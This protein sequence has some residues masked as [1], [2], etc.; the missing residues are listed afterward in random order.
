VRGPHEQRGGKEQRGHGRRESDDEHC[1]DRGSFLDEQRLRMRG[2]AREEEK[3]GGG[4]CNVSSVRRW[5]QL[6][7]GTYLQYRHHEHR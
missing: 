3:E 2:W 7:L 5:R 1:D 4:G 6:A